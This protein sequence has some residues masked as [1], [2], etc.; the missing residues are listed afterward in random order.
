MIVAAIFAGGEGLRMGGDKFLRRIRNRT[1]LELALA[2]AKA[3][4]DRVALSVRDSTQDLGADQS[5]LL[6]DDRRTAGP[7]AGLAA[8]LTWAHAE[9]A[10][11]VLT[12][13]CDTP[14]APRDL[15]ARLGQ[16]AKRSTALAAIARSDGVAHPAC[17]LWSV[18]LIAPLADYIAEGRL[19][20]I[21]FAER[22]GCAIADWPVAPFD[23]FFNVNTPEDLARAELIAD[24]LHFE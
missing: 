20:L 4:A 5:P 21:G 19:S 1:M 17:A 23:P 10:G 8:A 7:I 12:L 14:F 18:S 11:W 15:A 9:E 24:Q 22:V 6:L 2:C 13:P 16:A 3:Q